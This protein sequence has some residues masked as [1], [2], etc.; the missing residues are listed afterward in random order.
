MINLNASHTGLLAYLT[1][2]EQTRRV[3]VTAIRRIPQMPSQ[4]TNPAGQI[5]SSHSHTV[6]GAIND[7]PST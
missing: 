2:S 6:C 3:K 7:L 5:G 4:P 1:F